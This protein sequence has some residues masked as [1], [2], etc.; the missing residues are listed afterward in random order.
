MFQIGRTLVSEEILEESFVCDLNACKGACCVE[1]SAGAPLEEQETRVLDS[2]FPKVRQYL[3]P[4]GVRAI[5]AQGTFVKGADG[6][7]ETPLVDG[8]ECAYVVFKEGVAR[9]GIEIAQKAGAVSWKKPV[10]CHLYPVR[11]R[12]YS[13]ITAVNYHQWH[14]C[15]AACRLGQKLKV[16]VYK[17]VKEALIRKFGNKWYEELEAVAEEHLRP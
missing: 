4:E 11:V 3:R 10:S 15:D 13:R 8:R 7:W 6:D 12:E 14:I 2:I 5:E 1:G 9:C 16:P 17:F